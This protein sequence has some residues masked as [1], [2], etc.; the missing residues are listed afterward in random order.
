MNLTLIGMPGAGKSTVGVVL[1]KTLG[2]D[3]ID[4]DL[5][6]Q[7]TMNA[8]LYEL[9]DSYGTEGFIELENRIL[10]GIEA[11]NAVIATGGSAV[12]GEDAMRHFASMGDIVYL[13]LPCEALVP[14]LGDLSRRGVV[15]RKGS[16]LQELYAE[17]A[18]LYEAH[19]AHTVD[20]DGRSLTQV[21]AAVAHAA[22]LAQSD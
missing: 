6:I 18:P 11:E 10:S 4:T 1:A 17:R 20:V 12:Y 21:V 19:A 13:R 2:M 22:G 9:I 8:R 5:V 14:R 15:M 16:T 7:R 3:F